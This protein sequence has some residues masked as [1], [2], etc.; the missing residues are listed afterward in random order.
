MSYL[1]SAA[2][3]LAFLTY[4]IRPSP[5]LQRAGTRILTSAVSIA[6]FAIAAFVGIRGAWGKALVLV[7][8]GAG[9]ALSARM[10]L[11]AQARKVDQGWM[12]LKEAR[13]LL[14]L[15]ATATPAE[16]RQAHRRLMQRAHPDKGGTA[17][18]AAQ[19]NAARD[20][21]LKP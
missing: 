9:L 6:L 20:R 11:R 10:P 21:L 13:D 1:I 8:L 4:I 16:V 18:L 14:G 2:L 19:L 15:D 3:F 17:G 12:G 5:V 7:V